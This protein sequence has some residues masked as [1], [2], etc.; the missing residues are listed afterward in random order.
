MEGLIF[1]ILRY[2]A[3]QK[4]NPDLDSVPPSVWN[5]CSRFSDVISRENQWW[6]LEMSAFSQLLISES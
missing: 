5:F 3:N 1:G 6:R 4:H 2:S